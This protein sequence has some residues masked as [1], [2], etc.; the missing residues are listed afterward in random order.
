LAAFPRLFAFSFS[1][2]AAPGFPILED[3]I[4]TVREIPDPAQASRG[5]RRRS[6][7][8]LEKFLCG[9]EMAPI[10]RAVGG[11]LVAD[12]LRANQGQADPASARQVRAEFN[13]R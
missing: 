4:R 11:K 7:T 1:L 5:P 12:R 6:A 10:A 9:G 3:R 2:A 13:D 8:T